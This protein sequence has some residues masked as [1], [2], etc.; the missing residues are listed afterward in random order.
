MRL[1]DKVHMTMFA[2]FVLSIAALAMS[3]PQ[4]DRSRNR[5]QTAGQ[6]RATQSEEK[7]D[8][9]KKKMEIFL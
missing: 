2:M 4:D 8:E 6:Q 5:R 1:R 3:L 9:Q 7:K